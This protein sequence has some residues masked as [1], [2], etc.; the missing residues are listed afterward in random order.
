M[1]LGQMLHLPVKRQGLV[2][3]WRGSNV[4]LPKVHPV[5]LCPAKHCSPEEDNPLTPGADPCVYPRGQE[6]ELGALLSQIKDLIQNSVIP[7]LRLS[8]ILQAGL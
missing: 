4:R 1:R 8:A 5:V 6:K 2:F 7:S 3:E